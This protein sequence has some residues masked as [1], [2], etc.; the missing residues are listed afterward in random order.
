MHLFFTPDLNGNHYTLN[1]TESKHCV[2]VLRLNEGDKIQLVDG[3][4]SFF[5][6][7]IVAAHPKACQVEITDAQHGVGKRD[8]R[9]HI[10]IGPTKSIDRFEWFLEKTT[11]I[12]IDEITPLLCRYS[13][14][15]S[16]KPVRLGNII[17][18]AMKQSLKAYR[19]VLNEMT[20]FRD[21]VSQDFDGGKY[22]AHCGPAERKLFSHILPKGKDA[23]ILIGPEGD[24]SPEEI[25]LA[26]NNGFH[27]VSLGESRLRTE[28]AGVVACHT[29]NLIN[30]LK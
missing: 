25:Q 17:T 8:F 22:I 30:E 13:E 3:K 23:L 15:K 11:E 20:S 26:L 2:R 9:L 16:I 14:R 12:G 19:P 24:F 29:V 18:S 28:T 10:A 6:A 4:G 5:E 7:V 21:F 27:P 1:E